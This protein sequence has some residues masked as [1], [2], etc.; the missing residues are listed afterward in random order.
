MQKATTNTV[1]RKEIRSTIKDVLNLTEN[2]AIDKEA[3]TKLT[4]K[5]EVENSTEYF[6]QFQNAVNEISVASYEACYGPKNTLALAEEIPVLISNFEKTVHND[7]SEIRHIF[8]KVLCLKHKFL[9]KNAFKSIVKRQ[10]D[11]NITIEMEIKEFFDKLKLDQ[12]YR[13]FN[14]S[15]ELPTLA[16]VVD[17][18]GSMIEEINAVKDLIKAIIG[19]ERR[20]PQW[21]ILNTFNDPG[22]GIKQYTYQY[23]KLYFI[24]II[25]VSTIAAT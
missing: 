19:T 10:E 9:A 20:S 7:P 22:N 13:L 17:T 5:I 1:V 11:T 8:G 2:V 21:Y 14:F 23:I 18:T 12:F 6:V 15:A 16:F 4:A 24:I 25:K 3:F